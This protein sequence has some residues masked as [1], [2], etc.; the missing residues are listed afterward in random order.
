MYIAIHTNGVIC[1][2]LY[3]QEEIQSYYEKHQIIVNGEY[4]QK[5]ILTYQEALFPGMTLLLQCMYV[6]L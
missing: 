4:V 2:M 1:A 5:P 3:S 6:R